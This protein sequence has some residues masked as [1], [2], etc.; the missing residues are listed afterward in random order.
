M[1][2]T[3]TLLVVVSYLYFVTLVV[4]DYTSIYT[5]LSRILCALSNSFTFY[6]TQ[7]YLSVMCHIIFI[8]KYQSNSFVC[9]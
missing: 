1:I 3:V 5:Y 9:N 2:I 4:C 7:M 6:V 8:S